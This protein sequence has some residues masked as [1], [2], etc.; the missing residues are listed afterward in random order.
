MKFAYKLVAAAGFVFLLAVSSVGAADL[1][2]SGVWDRIITIKKPGCSASTTL[3]TYWKGNNKRTEQLAVQGVTVDIKRGST[4]YTYVP[5]K[6]AAIRM[7]VPQKYASK[8]VSVQKELELMA[9]QTKATVR[10]AKKIGSATVA[11]IK[12]DVYK[13]LMPKGGTVRIY[14]SADPRFPLPLRTVASV[15]RESE[16]TETR[17]IKLGGD[18]PDSMFSVPKGVKVREVKMREPAEAKSSS[19]K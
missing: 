9:A 14:V 2:K 18:V 10:K 13:V 6:K 19:S 8:D 17:S 3:K 16:T 11:G 1:A 12:C 15:G 4:R 5:A 7:V